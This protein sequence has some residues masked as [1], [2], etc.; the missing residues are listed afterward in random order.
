MTFTW[1]VLQ[2][3]NHHGFYFSEHTS[4]KAKAFRHHGNVSMSEFIHCVFNWCR[5]VTVLKE[6]V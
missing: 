3:L 6:K 4:H 2:S 5:S 1:H